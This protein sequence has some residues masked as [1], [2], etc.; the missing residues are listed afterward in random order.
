MNSKAE[1]VVHGQRVGEHVLVECSLCGPVGI[2]KA[3]MYTAI[4]THAQ[5]HKEEQ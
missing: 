3:P 4:E 5:E 2:H 1:V